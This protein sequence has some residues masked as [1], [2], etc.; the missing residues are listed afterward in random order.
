MRLVGILF[1]IVV[2]LALL[3]SGISIQLAASV[4]VFGVI[5]NI[6]NM[7]AKRKYKHVRK[8]KHSRHICKSNKYSTITGGETDGQKH[9]DNQ[10]QPVIN[11]SKE[12]TNA[13][14]Q[15][16]REAPGINRGKNPLSCCAIL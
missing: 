11:N 8:L 14:N 4:V 12:Y 16:Q 3:L 7:S 5:A 15:K 10:N 13:D 1:A 9:V 2:L 6:L